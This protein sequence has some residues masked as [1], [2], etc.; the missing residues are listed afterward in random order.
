LAGI[1]TSAGSACIAR[2]KQ[3]SPVLEALGLPKKQ[4]LESI[5]FTLGRKTTKK[6]IE[7]TVS[8]IVKIVK[9]GT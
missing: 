7:V 8:S 1:A 5:R 9:K 6:D 4:C 2:L 3:P